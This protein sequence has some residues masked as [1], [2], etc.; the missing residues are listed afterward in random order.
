[1]FEW[2][3]KAKDGHRVWIEVS[4]QRAQF[5]GRDILLA[6]GRDITER[7]LATEVSTYRDHVRHAVTQSTAKLVAGPSLADAMPRALRIAGE[8]LQADRLLVLE[9]GSDT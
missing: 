4:L 3:C 7:R 6:T 8:A 1:M 5:C 2:P 9:R